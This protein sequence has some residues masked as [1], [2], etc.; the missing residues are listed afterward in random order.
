MVIDGLG[1]VLWPPILQSRHKQAFKAEEKCELN[2]MAEQR[3]QMQNT[4]SDVDNN[5]SLRAC[6]QKIFLLDTLVIVLFV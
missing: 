3:L 2:T 4:S 5:L 1:C 6:N